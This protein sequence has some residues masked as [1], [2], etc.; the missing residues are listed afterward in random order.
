[1]CYK[2][3]EIDPFTLWHVPDKY[4]TQGMCLK[5]VEKDPGLL[6]IVP[7]WFVTHQ[8]VEVWCDESE[9]DNDDYKFSEW[10]DGYKKG[11]AQE[12]KIKED[13]LPI[14][15]HSNCVMNWCMSEDEKRLWK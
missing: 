1:M 3:T 15:W 10:Y 6:Q 14:A 7:D 2:S 4:K 12:A 9:Y 8:Q 13:L 5:A 11:K